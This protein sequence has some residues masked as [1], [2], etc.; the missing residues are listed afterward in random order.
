MKSPPGYP[1][2]ADLRAALAPLATSLEA[3]KDFLKVATDLMRDIEALPLPQQAKE[4]LSERYGLL[5]RKMMHA[6]KALDRAVDA[7]AAVGSPAPSAGTPK[8]VR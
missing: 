4:R 5:D 1:P 2:A 8:A 3:N 7:Y 6:I